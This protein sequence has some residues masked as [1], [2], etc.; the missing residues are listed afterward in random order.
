MTVTAAVTSHEAEEII[1]EL[2][3]RGPHPDP[4]TLYDRLRAISPVIY[5]ENVGKWYVTGFDEV[6]EVHTKHA[7]LGQGK[8]PA[9]K[10]DPRYHDSSY[11]QFLPRMTPWIDQPEHTR[12]RKLF[13][14]AF[15][16]RRINSLSESIAARVHSL[17]DAAEKKPKPDLVSDVAEQLPIATIC[18]LLG[19]PDRIRG[20]GLEWA[21]EM[22]DLILV[23]LA[24]LSD[25]ELARGNKVISEASAY[26]E[27]VIAERRR[28][29][30]DDLLSA[31]VRAEDGGDR[32]TTDEMVS[33]AFQ[34]FI[35]ASET[36]VGTLS[37][38]T[39][40]LLRN[41]DQLALLRA[42]P[43]LGKAAVE[44]YLRYEAPVQ[45]NLSRVALEDVTIGGVAIPK[46]A[47]VSPVLGAANRDGRQ[48]PDP[49][50]FDITRA[51]QHLSFGRGI[52]LCIGAPLA[53][54]QVSIAVGIFVTRYPGLE[55]D[56]EPTLRGSAGL[57]ALKTLPVK[58]R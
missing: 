15:S 48:F 1:A 58:L 43:E 16:A 30:G 49:H 41:P 22:A 3:A 10:L 9:P 24:S 50:R 19:L 13:A 55:L 12:L 26:F 42:Q 56:G 37:M 46:G 21:Q 25:S 34:L 29:P 17:L 32:M 54:L 11:L 7:Q 35:A 51:P 6:A 5:S 23:P 36:S 53:R 45:I 52:H 57:R 40:W 14:P 20:I 33:L 18:N 39:L 4:Y 8:T 47:S 2:I 31:F 38:G 28:A 44:E 27:E